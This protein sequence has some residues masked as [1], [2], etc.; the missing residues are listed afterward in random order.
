MEFGLPATQ[1]VPL[2]SEETPL[3]SI[4]TLALFSLHMPLETIADLAAACAAP[5][6]KGHLS[7]PG[8]KAQIS[9][10]AGRASAAN[11]T[12]RLR[13][14]TQEQ[15]TVLRKLSVKQAAHEGLT[16]RKSTETNSGFLNVYALNK[17]G[18]QSVTIYYQARRME[19][20]VQVHY[21]MF[22]TA[23]EAALQMA[24]VR[25]KTAPKKKP[26]QRKQAARNPDPE[27]S[28]F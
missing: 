4:F 26:A 16:L 13:P 14:A 8:F 7:G 27:P 17:G 1:A 21:G 6:Q 19:R 5:P 10:I 12:P 25:K 24:R 28:I 15:L 18:Y 2:F 11:P 23:E 20:G 3:F 9:R 22:L